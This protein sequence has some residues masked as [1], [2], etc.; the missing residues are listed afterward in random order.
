MI[1]FFVGL[2]IGFILRSQLPQFL[3]S[4]IIAL[5]IATWTAAILSLWAVKIVSKT[6]NRPIPTL[7]ARYHTVSSP[8]VDQEWSQH[9]LH[10]QY[11]SLLSLPDKLRSPVDPESYLG[12]QI[13]LVLKSCTSNKLS[14]LAKQAFPS[15]DSLIDRSS[16][17]FEDG[18]VLIELISVAH[19][20]KDDGSMR[21][22]SCESGSIIRVLVGCEARGVSRQQIT[23]AEMYK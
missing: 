23:Q 5:G 20:R 3:Y 6:R 22:I 21:A 17:L 18:I 12:Q 16:K 1:G 19:L 2:P 8:G 14:S 4:D 11:D 13:K 7:E 9:E 15:T 10:I